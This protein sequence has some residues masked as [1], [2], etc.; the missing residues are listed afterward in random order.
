VHECFFSKFPQTC[1][2][3]TVKNDLEKNICISLWAPLFST[4]STSSPIFAEMSPNNDVHEN[5]KRLHFVFGRH[6]FQIKAPQAILR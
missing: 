6:F 2:R 4:Q 3:K 1:P 5:K